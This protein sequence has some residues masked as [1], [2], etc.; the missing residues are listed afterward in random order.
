MSWNFEINDKT[1]SIVQS[2]ILTAKVISQLRLIVFKIVYVSADD[3]SHLEYIS[4][5]TT[6]DLVRIVKQINK[7]L[8]SIND[9]YNTRSG[10][11]SFLINVNLI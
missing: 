6:V 3:M 2:K 9:L 5:Q 8:Y 11:T 1:K 10:D 4:L 7:R